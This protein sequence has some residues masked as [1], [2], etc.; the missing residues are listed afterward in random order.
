MKEGPKRVTSI[1]LTEAQRLLLDR[2]GEISGRSRS[3]FL[4]QSGILVAIRILR[5][6]GQSEQHLEDLD[7]G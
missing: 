6:H 3:E 2:A 4:R 5:D 1:R 7:D